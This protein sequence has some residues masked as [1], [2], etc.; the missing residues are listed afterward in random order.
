MA[1]VFVSYVRENEEQ[2]RRLCE[3]L[4]KHGVETWLAKYDIEPG[5][6]W[7]ES[8]RQA[9]EDTPQYRVR[10]IWKEISSALHSRGRFWSVYSQ[11]ELV[12]CLLGSETDINRDI[13]S[14]KNSL[15]DIFLKR[16]IKSKIKFA[17]AKIKKRYPIRELLSIVSAELKKRNEEVVLLKDSDLVNFLN[18]PTLK[19]SDTSKILESIDEDI[20]EKNRQLLSLIENLNKE[21]AKSKEAFFQIK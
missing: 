9:I 12:G 2:V 20:E 15:G 3:D 7:K 16:D 6:R 14:L 5:S 18:A 1:H 4:S 8:I 10:D 21:H 13:Q 19:I 11:D 17:Y